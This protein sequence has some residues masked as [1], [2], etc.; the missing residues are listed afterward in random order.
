[1]E[2]FRNI[3]WNPLMEDLIDNVFIND[4]RMENESAMYKILNDNFKDP[5]EGIECEYTEVNVELIK[6]Y[7]CEDNEDIS[8]D[9]EEENCEPKNNVQKH[10]SYVPGIRILPF[11]FPR[12]SWLDSDQQAMCL[13]VL[14]RLSSNTNKKLDKKEKMEFEHY[15]TLQKMIE[16]EQKEYL[17]FAKSQWDDTFKW[18][19]KCPEFVIKK[20]KAKMIRFQK[21]PRYY[22][23][24]I[25][26]PL[27][28]QKDNDKN[29]DIKIKFISC[30]RQGS[31]SNVILPKLDRKY[32][33]FMNIPLLQ[34]YKPY[35]EF[36]KVMQHFRLPVSEDTYCESLAIEAGVDLIISSSGIK[37]LLSNLDS[38]HSNSWIIPVVVKLHHGKNV[39]YIDKKLPSM[40]ATISQKNF[41]TYKYS[42]KYHFVDGKEEISETTEKFKKNQSKK[43]VDHSDSDSDD[44]NSHLKLYEED[45]YLSDTDK[46]EKS[47]NS[48]NDDKT[49]SETDMQQNVSYK[50]F[51]IGPESLNQKVKHNMKD[52]KMLVRTKIDG[53]ETL[54][55]GEKQSLILAPKIEHQLGFGAEAITLEEGLHQW[56]SLKFRPETSLAR[57][58][59]AADNNEVIQI[60]KLTITSLTSEIKRLFKIKAEDSL[61]VLYNMIEQLSS[62]TPG[63]YIMRHVPRNGPFASIYKQVSEYGKNIF[64]LHTICNAKFETISKTPWPPL[65]NMLTTPAIICFNRMP[66]MFYPYKNKEVLVRPKKLKGSKKNTGDALSKVAITLR[67][68]TR[69]Q[70]K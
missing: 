36:E 17:E 6:Q 25:N 38:D 53:I 52:Y 1:M 27:S 57:V 8:T 60:E 15:M 54:P 37:C 65:D 13:R 58:R 3:D 63:Q 50:L 20:W 35:V 34:R 47:D 66:A 61:G 4:E 16:D 31:F 9:I 24:S 69:L 5:F 30:L 28:L 46:S 45:L 68:S 62:L 70:S 59:I 64:D 67:R 21:L 41:Y 55:S 32:T 48:A 10:K 22:I 26:I 2:K 29:K 42:L 14:L 12:R 33:L 43:N 11:Y 51:T 40:S 7:L 23:E 56:A 18:F 39:V 19:S 44:S 49:D